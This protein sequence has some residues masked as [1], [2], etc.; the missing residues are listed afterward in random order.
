MTVPKRL[1][2]RVAALEQAA[3]PEPVTVKIIFHREIVDRDEDGN[4]VVVDEHE[5]VI[6]S[7]VV[8]EHAHRFQEDATG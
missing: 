5:R 3:D 4:L 6:E 2:D 8:P 7:R 1:R